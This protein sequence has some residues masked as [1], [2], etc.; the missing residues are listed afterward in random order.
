[1]TRATAGLL[2]Q[3]IAREALVQLHDDVKGT[4]AR[5]MP[6][7]GAL[8]VA[9]GIRKA[10]ERPMIDVDVLVEPAYARAA[11]VAAQKRGWSASL[12]NDAAC[13]LIHPK[14]SSTSVDLHRTL[15]PPFYY[16]MDTE[17]VFARA[18]PDTKLFGREIMRMS[19]LDLYAHLVGHFVKSRTDR[20][21]LRHLRD[22]APV[23]RWSGMSPRECAAH[24][25]RVGLARGARYALRLAADTENDVFAREV[26]SALGRDRR[27]RLLARTADAALSRLEPGSHWGIPFVH[28]LNTSVPRGARSLYAH[29]TEPKEDDRSRDGWWRL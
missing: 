18:T 13:M 27:G 22:F 5:L 14:T 17:G 15:F 12:G 25:E 6:L 4:G 16:R 29:L 26:L 8:L 2:Q 28:A 11:A 19:P 20:R 3:L 7:K 24:L 9:L 23:A 10:G 1:M 21:D